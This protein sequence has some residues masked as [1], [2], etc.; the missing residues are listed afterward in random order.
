MTG[1][2]LLDIFLSTLYFFG[3][4]LWLLL[5]FWIIGDIFRSRDLSGAAKAAWLIIVI[6]L[7]LIGIVL[8]LI[9]RGSGMHER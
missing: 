9:V 4:V 5:M 7:P 6:I 1:Y 8:Y 2:P 3:W